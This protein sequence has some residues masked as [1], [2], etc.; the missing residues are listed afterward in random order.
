MTMRKALMKAKGALGRWEFERLK[1]DYLR[2][3]TLK[4]CVSCTKMRSGKAEF[5]LTFTSL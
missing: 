1:R 3:P 5:L 4:E 2:F